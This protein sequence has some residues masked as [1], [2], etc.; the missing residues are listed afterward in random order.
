[1]SSLPRRA[2]LALRRGW[3]LAP[4]TPTLVVPLVLISRLIAADTGSMARVPRLVAAVAKEEWQWRRRWPAH[5]QMALAMRRGRPLA[6]PPALVVPLAPQSRLVAAVAGEEWQSGVD[7]PHVNGVHL[8][9]GTGGPP[10]PP[11][12]CLLFPWW[13]HDHVCP[14]WGSGRGGVNVL[15]APR[16][17]AL[18]LRHGRPLAPPPQRACRSPDLPPPCLLSPWCR[19][20]I[21]LSP[22]R[23]RSGR[24]E[25][26]DFVL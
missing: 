25:A 16:R 13:R 9:C 14:P 3:P 1:M 2:A 18:A 21:R 24:S 11:P 4:P 6:L 15:L 23:R 8:C 12:L 22:L 20:H 17:A 26:S 7:G 10:T 19:D 5:Q